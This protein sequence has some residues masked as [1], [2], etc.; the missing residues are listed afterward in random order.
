MR[1]NFLTILI[2]ELKPWINNVPN[3]EIYK[4]YYETNI[5]ETT[6]YTINNFKNN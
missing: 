6:V 1:L 5:D 3:N 2:S 4:H